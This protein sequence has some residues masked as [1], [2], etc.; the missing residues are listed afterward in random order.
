M[1]IN[2]QYNFFFRFRRKRK[3][4]QIGIVY[5]A[6][7]EHDTDGKVNTSGLCNE[8]SVKSQ[9]VPERRGSWIGKKK[10]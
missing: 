7:G 9:K 8:F 4:R 1:N 5:R 3:F 6:F 2:Q 10:W